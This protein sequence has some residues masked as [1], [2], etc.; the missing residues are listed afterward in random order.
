MKSER[1]ISLDVFR[2]ITITGMILVN[3]PGSWSNIYPPLRHAAWHGCTPTDLIFPF[4]L[5]IVGV[6]IT[7]SLTKH[8]ASGENR[9][10]ITLNIFR[11]SII[12]FML[13]LLLHAF[14]YFNFE[15]LRIPGV[16]QRIS[17]VYLISSFIFLKTSIRFQV[18]FTGL[19]LIGYWILMTVVPVPGIGSANLEKTTNFAAWFDNLLLS[20][21][22]WRY[23]KVWDPEGII[24]TIP[25]ISST[26]IG[27]L[28]GHWLQTKND[29]VVKTVWIFVFGCF[30]MLAGYI[31]DGWFPMNKNL[32]T[33]SY[34][35]YTGGL[36]LNFLAVCF[37][38]IDVKGI[39][40]W[41]KPFQIYGMNAITVFFF[42][43]IVAKLLYIIKVTDLA[44][45]EIS[46]RSYLYDNLFLT[47]L[48]PINASLFWAIIYVL[49]WLSLMWVLY[50]RRIF[51]KI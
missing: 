27:I 36:A 13:G 12:L 48:S 7:L 4:F 22:L 34:V 47:W 25:A 19:I 21:H 11:R 8:K 40:W 32:W 30:L 51:I 50:S 37:W 28:T 10:K 26:L 2:G 17:I 9:T 14:P 23:T 49:F 20:G 46:V 5:F 43:G 1:L 16:L 35:L 38:F 3:N 45:N 31:W 15:T 29:K 39:S 33:S 24:S 42:S 6:A 44:G 41:I 18:I